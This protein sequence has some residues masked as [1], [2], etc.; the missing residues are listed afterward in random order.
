MA[1][2]KKILLIIAAFLLTAVATCICNFIIQLLLDIIDALP[3]RKSNS[4]LAI[5]AL[6]LVTGVFCTVFTIVTAEYF[7]KKENTSERQVMMVA[8]IIFLMI[9]AYSLWGLFAG[10]GKS[11][12]DYSFLFENPV[13][14]C[15]FAVGGGAMSI[16]GLFVLD[17]KQAAR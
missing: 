9:F 2:S 4:G 15:C 1:P 11:L 13:A 5:G 17:K 10:R 7:L 14:Q 16:I 3:L 6:W 8:T 12:M